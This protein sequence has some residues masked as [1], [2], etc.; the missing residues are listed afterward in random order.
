MASTRLACPVPFIPGQRIGLKVDD[1]EA[2]AA[3]ARSVRARGAGAGSVSADAPA[4]AGTFAAGPA[5]RTV[6]AAGGMGVL[7]AR[8]VGLDEEGV[9]RNIM[10]FV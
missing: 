7:V 3:L 2:C 9:F 10:T 8:V 5:P 1:G 6:P 4:E